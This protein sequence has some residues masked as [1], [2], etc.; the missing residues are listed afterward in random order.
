VL[1]VQIVVQIFIFSYLLLFDKIILLGILFDEAWLD[2]VNIVWELIFK[3]VI[4]QIFYEELVIRIGVSS[5][6]KLLLLE[7]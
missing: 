2:I 7:S 1:S 6:N 3:F 4:S 5:F